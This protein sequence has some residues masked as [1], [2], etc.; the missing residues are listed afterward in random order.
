MRQELVNQAAERAHEAEMDSLTGIANRRLLDGKIAKEVSRCAR[1]GLPL[2]VIMIDI[3]HFK[4]FNDVHGHQAGDHCLTHV[5]SALAGQLRRPS[6]LVARYGGEEFCVVLPETFSE[7]ACAIAE[8]MRHAISRLTLQTP[9]G[10][11]SVTISLGVATVVPTLNAKADKWIAMADSA[12][13]EAKE[14]GRNVVRRAGASL[15]TISELAASALSAR[16]TANS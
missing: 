1:S 10:Q 12:L 4:R 13:Y 15:A 14:G 6:D 8:Q 5:A 9:Q 3:D 11:A 2:S 7:G 16:S